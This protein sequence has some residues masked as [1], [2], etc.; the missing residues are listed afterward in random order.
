MGHAGVVAFESRRHAEQL[1]VVR[2]RPPGATLD[3]IVVWQRGKAAGP[4]RALLDALTDKAG[5]QG[6]SRCSFDSILDLLENSS[7]PKGV[8]THNNRGAG[9]RGFQPMKDKLSAETR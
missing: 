2:Q 7:C 8:Q 1:S 5:K 3:L 9:L 6:K 4:L